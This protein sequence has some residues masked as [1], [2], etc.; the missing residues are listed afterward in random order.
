[1]NISLESIY[2]YK[3]NP[4]PAWPNT[5]FLLKH[6]R[7]KWVLNLTHNY[8]KD[9]FR[10]IKRQSTCQHWLPYSNSVFEKIIKS[11]F[12]FIINY[13]Y[14]YYNIIYF[15]ESYWKNIPFRL[16]N[17]NLS[18]YSSKSLSFQSCDI[19]YHCLPNYYTNIIENINC[20]IAEWN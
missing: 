9:I 17:I 5:L 12:V 10:K 3:K 6:S 13:H 16:K 19:Y 15:A 7:L 1:M 14:L 11:K 8:F 2:I 20:K 4:K 18:L